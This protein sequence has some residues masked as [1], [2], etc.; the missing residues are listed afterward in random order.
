MLYSKLAITFDS[1]VWI[2]VSVCLV[3]LP[4]FFGIISSVFRF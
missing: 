3:L 2:R 1:N 4:K